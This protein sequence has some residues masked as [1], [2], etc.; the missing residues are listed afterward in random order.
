MLDICQYYKFQKEKRKKKLKA[1]LEMAK[2]LQ[3]T[4]H[5]S[6]VE[7]NKHEGQTVESFAE[8]MQKVFLFYHNF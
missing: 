8:F 1:K 3:K 2:F 5:E 4:V 7:V 6:A